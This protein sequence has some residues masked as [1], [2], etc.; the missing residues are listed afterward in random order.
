MKITERQE[1]ILNKL[2]EDYV[3]SAQPISSEFLEK[4]HGFGLSSATL[5]IEMQKLTDGG[6]LIQPHTSSGRV[7]TD[8]GYR[9]FVDRLLKKRKKDIDIKGWLEDDMQDAIKFLQSLT[10][11][12]AAESQSLVF[13]YLKGEDIFWKEGWQKILR[14]PEFGDQDYALNFVK[15]LEDFEKDIEDF[16]VNAGIKI[17]IGREN[18]FNK[19]SDF[20]MIFSSCRLPESK[21]GI[22]SL[23]GPKRMDYGRNINLI[24][25]LTELLEKF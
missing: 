14:E 20:S 16:D 1:K 15:F 4:K 24:N 23:V 2:I 6:Y 22:F 9:F 5:R 17:Y 11:K 7:P 13:S 18:P 25:S 10:R 12:L 19:A 8:K 21:Q 3:L